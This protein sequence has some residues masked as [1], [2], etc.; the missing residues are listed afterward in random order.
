M[1]RNDEPLPGDAIDA[2]CAP[3]VVLDPEG[4]ILRFNRALEEL[5]GFP[6][7]E[8]CGRFLW[9][10]VLPPSEYAVVRAAVARVASGATVGAGGSY[11][12]SRQGPA[13]Y[14]RWT[15]RVIRAADGRVT[16][17]VATARVNE[18]DDAE[19]EALRRSEARY[20]TLVEA[21]DDLIWAV[22]AG[23]RVTFVNRRAAR[24]IYDREP[25]AIVGRT[26]DSLLKEHAPASRS[27]V[28]RVLAGEAVHGHEATHPRGDGT[29]VHLLFNALPVVDGSGSVVAVTGTAVDITDRK[30]A[31]AAQEQHAVDLERRVAERTEA[32]RETKDDLG[33]FLFSVSHHLRAPLRAVHLFGELLLED[34]ADGLD[35]RGTDYARRIVRA[36]ARMDRLLVDLISYCRVG[37]TPIEIGDVPVARVVEDVLDHLQP[38]LAARGAEVVVVEPLPSVRAS[39][40]VLFQ[41]LVQLLSNAVT[42]VAP[43]RSPQVTIAAERRDGLAYVQVRDNGVGIEPGMQERVFQLFERARSDASGSTGLGLAIVRRAVERMGGRVGL[44]STPGVGTTVWLELPEASSRQSQSVETT[45]TASG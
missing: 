37:R 27:L 34:N 7:G 19:L 36:A 12:H 11:W 8:V 16:H 21:S 28:E 40:A 43:G 10:A 41:A 25:E 38:E 45:P 20:R 26:L 5:S 14:A 29:V 1:V 33:S 15:P 13:W 39:R 32:L 17:I 42:Y 30:R 3:V 24:R 18:A 22:D 31:E 6:T 23:M 35:E 4:R 2:V 44:E 9:D